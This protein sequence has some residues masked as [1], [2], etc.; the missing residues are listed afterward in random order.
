M[1]LTRVVDYL[2][3]RLHELHPD[4]RLREQ[5]RIDLHNGRLHALVAGCRLTPYQVPV[6]RTADGQVF[7]Y[8]AQLIA[9]TAQGQRIRPES[10][11]VQAWD[12]ADVVFLDRFLRTLHALHHLNEGRG[13]HELLVVTVHLRHLSALP[14]QHGRVFEDLLA[15]LGLKPSQVVVRLNGPALQQDPH[16]RA[17]AASFVRRGYP[18]AAIQLDPQDIDWALLER[19]GVRWVTPSLAALQ[20]LRQRGLLDEWVHGALTR[21]ILVWLDQIETPALLDLAHALGAELAE[22]EALAQS[23]V[24][25]GLVAAL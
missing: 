22:G 4:A 24:P 19:I 11:Y 21:R 3:D 13:S 14:E 1:P 25:R 7:G 5:A 2:N 6:V 9:H 15:R 12:A 8:S 10:L 16:V 20:G 23:M 18:L 17:A